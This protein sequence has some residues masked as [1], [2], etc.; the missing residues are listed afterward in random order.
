MSEHHVVHVVCSDA[1]AGVERYVLNSALALR[2]AGFRVTVVGGAQ[3][4]LSSP[5]RLAGVDWL[6]GASIRQALRSL[7]RVRDVDLLNTHMTNADLVG[8]LVGGIR[9]IPVVSTRHFAS[10]RGSSSVA[11]L[12]S[13]GIRR[14]VAAQI[15]ISEFVS[16]NIEG[17]STVVYTGVDDVVDT[18]A[19]GR[20]A[21]VLVSQR[22]EKEKSTDQALRA[23]ALVPERGPWRLVVGGSGSERSALEALARE[24]RIDDSVDF[25]GFQEDV[26]LLLRR[27]SIFLAPTPREGLGI[28]VIEAMASALPVVAARGG[29]HLESVGPVV[30]SAL[31][32]PDDP[33][34]AA[35]ELT[36]LMG[37]ESAREA[38]GRALCDRQRAIF[39]PARQTAGTI[40]VFAAV[41]SS[42][43][44]R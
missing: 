42:R 9:R 26:G 16:S 22:L 27:A 25:L 44:P 15:A 2:G 19:A 5:L 7:N 4:S 8:V 29:G 33:A 14:R 1:F 10:T 24:L 35:V 20:R 28:A 36:R 39:T 12:V 30:G 37:D 17:D 13:T 18:P 40:A 34:A 23:W 6:P 11:R 32:D 31:F 38:Y 21:E 3:S 41:L 43:N